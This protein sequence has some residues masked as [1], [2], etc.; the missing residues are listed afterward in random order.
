MSVD[1]FYWCET[2]LGGMITSE[3]VPA[4]WGQDC[5][6]SWPIRLGGICISQKKKKERKKGIVK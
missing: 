5:L 6:K 2:Y 1:L 4:A 3:W